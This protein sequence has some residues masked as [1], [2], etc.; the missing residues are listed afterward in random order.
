M[1]VFRPP[2][3]PAPRRHPRRAIFPQATASTQPLHPTLSN[4]LRRVGTNELSRRHPRQPA[5]AQRIGFGHLPSWYRLA[6]I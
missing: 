3:D 5:A 2:T 6:R 1:L 4:S